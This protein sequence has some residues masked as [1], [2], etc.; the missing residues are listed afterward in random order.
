MVAPVAGDRI[1]EVL[2]ARHAERSRGS[3]ASALA[4]RLQVD[5]RTLGKR[6]HPTVGQHLVG[7]PQL[8]AT[9]AEAKGATKE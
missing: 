6:L 7:D 4:G 5:P 9:I 8:L 3:L 1:P 2:S